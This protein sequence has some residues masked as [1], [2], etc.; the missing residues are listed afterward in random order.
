MFTGLV[1]VLRLFP[2]CVPVERVQHVFQQI[3]FGGL[4]AEANRS[5]ANAKRAHAVC[6][7]PSGHLP[8]PVERVPRPFF[9]CVQMVQQF[10]GFDLRQVVFF[11]IIPNVFEQLDVYGFVIITLT[12]LFITLMRLFMTLMTLFITLMAGGQFWQLDVDEF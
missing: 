10:S 7:L 11:N 2:I 9:E 3:A 6:E 4:G 1:T 5:A 8:P 12:T